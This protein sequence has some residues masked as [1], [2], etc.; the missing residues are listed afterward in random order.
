MTDFYVRLDYRQYKHLEDQLRHWEEIETTHTSVDGFYHKAL[1]VE[2][3]DVTFE[4]QGPV[5]KE[6]I[7]DEPT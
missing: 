6:P 4:F 2:V 5:V 7:R 1:R 3:G